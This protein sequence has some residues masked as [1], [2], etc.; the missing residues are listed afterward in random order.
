MALSYPSI[1]KLARETFSDENPIIVRREDRERWVREVHSRIAGLPNI[2][3][4]REKNSYSNREKKDQYLCDFTIHDP[5]HPRH[6]YR[7]SNDFTVE[8]DEQNRLTIRYSWNPMAYIADLDEL[9]NFVNGCNER[10][11]RRIVQRHKREK[12][13]ALKQQAIV[14]QVKK[15]GQQE[16]FNFT[17]YAD[18]VKLRL[19][20]ELSEKDCIELQIPFNKFEQLLP[21]LATIIRSALDLYENGVKF[22]MKKRSDFGYSDWIRYEELE[23]D[24]DSD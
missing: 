14:S 7:H 12:V 10:L 11:E 17:T 15:L 18:T 6:S 4:N 20:V 21:K 8:V 19:I 2:S 5:D 16:Q 22:N 24:G 23:T 9:V 1:Y 13:R 3:F